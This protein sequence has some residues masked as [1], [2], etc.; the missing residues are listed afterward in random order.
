MKV[1]VLS[2]GAPNYHNFFNAITRKLTSE[3]VEV[4]YAVDCPASVAEN[5]VQEVGVDY[6]VFSEFFAAH[7][8][9]NKLLEAY[10]LILTA[11]KS[12]E[13]GGRARMIF[14]IG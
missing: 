8:I 9:D 6:S 5:R 12:M 7:D 4:G 3:G 10:S 11:Q 14:M 13:S 2:N 1:L